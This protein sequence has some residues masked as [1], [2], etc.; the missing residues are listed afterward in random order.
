MGQSIRQ[1]A[2]L[3]RALLVTGS[4]LNAAGVVDATFM[5]G[6]VFDALISDKADSVEPIAD[7]ARAM[8][9][10]RIIKTPDEVVAMVRKF[11]TEPS[12]NDNH[13]TEGREGGTMTPDLR[14]VSETGQQPAVIIRKSVTP[15]FI[16]CLEDGVKRKMLKRHLGTVY[17]MTP[18]QYRAK[19]GLPDDYPMTAPN[20]SKQ[21]SAYAHSVNFGT[22]STV[23]RKTPR[24]RRG[25]QA[26]AA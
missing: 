22:F 12:L 19:W 4:E 1:S 3:V 10:Q 13:L 20:Y 16:I 21:K 7:L 2:S 8:I 11:M 9:E 23:Y 14:P 25:A 17:G 5:I 26:Q 15:D 18:E 24:V 6:K